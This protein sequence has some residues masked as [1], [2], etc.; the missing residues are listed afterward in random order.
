MPSSPELL[1]QIETALSAFGTAPLPAAASELLRTLGYAS[2]RTLPIGSVDAFCR[3]FDS[4]GRLDHP[5]ALKAADP[6]RTSSLKSR[7][8]NL[9]LPR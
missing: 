8:W 1:K 2:D 7:R 3:Q 5:S 6:V 9:P 4:T